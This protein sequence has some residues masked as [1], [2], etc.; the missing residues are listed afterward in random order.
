MGHKKSPVLSPAQGRARP[1]DAG[2]EGFKGG[3]RAIRILHI[4]NDL[5]I[6][7]SELMLYKLLSRA[8][9]EGF[10]PTVIS[11]NGVGKLGDRVR[12][13]GIPVEA[14]GVKASRT[15][16]LSLLRLSRAVRRIKPDLIQG[17]MYHGNLAAQ[18]AAV[19]AP[20]PASVL[21]NIRQSL[22]S[23][24]DEKPATAKAI[25]L[26]ARLSNWPARI[27]N[28]SQKSVIQHTAIGYRGDRTVIIPNGFDTDSFVPSLEARASVRSELGVPGDTILV[29]RIGRYHHTKDYPTFLRAAA[30]LLRE[31]PDTQF[32]LAGKGVDW[33]NGELRGLAQ[34]LGLVERIHLLGERLDMP[35]ITAALDV[36]VSSSHTEGF[37]N[38]IGEAMACGVPC[39]ATDVGDSVLVIGDTGRVVP[40]G[41]CGSLAAACKDL[42]GLDSGARRNLGLAAR[43][44]IIDRYSLAPV[45]QRYESLYQEVFAERLAAD[46]KSKRWPASPPGEYA[47]LREVGERIAESSQSASP[48][49]SG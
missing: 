3:R 34:G 11:L 14:V 42:I 28:N 39:V 7:G 4:I 22:Y 27:L 21:W 43:S 26:G 35:R 29:G 24:Q 2:R 9:R 37:P 33:N 15:R 44:R 30:L 32:V 40:T 31:H 46:A 12:E 48:S 1:A 36:A 41:D 20:R 10:E 13:L 17:W 47:N 49:G 16:A 8:D 45:V 18:F 25:R 38:V 23:L 19:L 6:G 5:S